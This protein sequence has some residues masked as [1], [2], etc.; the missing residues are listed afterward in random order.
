MPLELA[1]NQGFHAFI[2]G[3][4]K[5][6]ILGPLWAIF[7]PKTSKEGTSKKSSIRSILSLYA[8]VILYK[9]I[10]KI[11]LVNFS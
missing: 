5:N 11:L 10:W 8:T 3:Y 1:K 2:F 6:L 9:K 4:L 7:G